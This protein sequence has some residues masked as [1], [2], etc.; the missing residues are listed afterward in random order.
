VGVLDNFNHTHTTHIKIMNMIPDMDFGTAE[1]QAIEVTQ[2]Y[3]T[4][5]IGTIDAHLGTGY[6]AKHPELIAQYMR[7][8]S[9][10]F[11]VVFMVT[12]AYNISNSFID[13]LREIAANQ[14]KQ[15]S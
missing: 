3:L 6:A 7:T 10:E 5:A 2:N 12:A 13:A 8:Q 15:K 4:S 1:E 11:N 9:A 14:L